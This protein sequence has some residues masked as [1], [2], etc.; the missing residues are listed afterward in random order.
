MKQVVLDFETF[1]SK[2]YSLRHMTPIEYV[3]D[4]RFELIGC[5]V[6][7]DEDEP[8]WV[9]GDK[10]ADYL[11]RLDATQTMLISHNAL[12][13]MC[14]T[15]WKF[16]F[17]PKLMVDTLGMARALLAH[18]I[19][20]GSLALGSCAMAL[21]LGVKG[22]TVTRVEGMNAAA[23]KAAGL[24]DAYIKYSLNDA[25]LCKGVFDKLKVE[26]PTTEYVVMDS[27]IRC[28]IIPQFELDQN[29]L[30]LH[31]HQIKEAKEALI[32]KCLLFGLK[33]KSELQS[34]EKF[35]EMLRLFGIEPPMKVSKTTGK[36]TYAFAKT[37]PSMMMLE[38]HDDIN[39]QALVAAR[40]G[41]KSTIEETRTQRLLNIARLTPKMPIPL[42][43]GGAHTHRLSGDWRLNMQNLPRGSAMRAALKAPPNHKVVTCDA[44]QIE[45][46]ITA[47]LCGQSNLVQQFQRGEDTYSIFASEVYGREI[48]KRDNPAE[49]FVGK[50]AILGLGFGMG[51]PRFY[52]QIKS[53]SYK[54]GIKIDIDLNECTRIVNVFRRTYPE[55]Q[56]TW[57]WLNS[58]LQEMTN[59]WFTE[60]FGPVT[61]EH[62]RI[63]L[64]N[65]LYLYYDNL[66][67]ENGGWVYTYGRETRKLFGGKVL[68]NI[69]QALARIIVFDAAVR[70]RQRLIRGYGIQ[71]AHTVHDELIYVTHEHCA[72]EVAQLVHD[73]M[74]KPPEWMVDLPLA[75]EVG[76]GD[77]YGE[78]K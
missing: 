60:N 25:V 11:S 37:D 47:R 17:I 50:Q 34:A 58:R 16:G 21:D 40:L 3:L 6:I 42:R 35:A 63:R 68:E 15:A 9:E 67:Q 72:G 55:F 56:R 61:M 77:N 62:N 78:A 13:D 38:M 74:V 22:D 71:L 65:G 64:P 52:N 41:V 33:D 49:R 4:P 75:A 53:D 26:F 24:H 36:E 8:F 28:A 5:A 29:L 32:G 27:I 23:I 20:T 43:Y 59:A 31:L 12:F 69:V 76:I 39:V 54:Q 1:Y 70:L 48:N 44:S 51:A 7:E 57:S 19:P 2:E 73:E 46:R 18:K 66:Q 45:A 30:A 10:F 14:I